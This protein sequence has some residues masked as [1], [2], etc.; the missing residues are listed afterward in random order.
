MARVTFGLCNNLLVAKAPRASCINLLGL[1][2]GWTLKIMSPMLT[3]CW[4]EYHLSHAL[5]YLVRT[6]QKLL[7]YNLVRT[8]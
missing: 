4:L 1:N 8:K 7:M 3:F 2:L 5:T 6:N